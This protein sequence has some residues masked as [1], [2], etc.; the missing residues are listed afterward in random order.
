ME[1]CE[2]VEKNRKI[3]FDVCEIVINGHMQGRN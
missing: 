1:K 3:W 2:I